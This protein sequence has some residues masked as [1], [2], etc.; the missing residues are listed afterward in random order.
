MSNAPLALRVHNSSAKAFSSDSSFFKKNLALG[1]SYFLLQIT[2]NSYRELCKDYFQASSRF[3]SNSST[4][5]D[6][7]FPESS[8]TNLSIGDHI[9]SSIGLISSWIELDNDDPVINDFSFQVLFNEISYA[10]FLGINTFLL[11]PPKNINNIQIY[12]SNISKILHSFPNISLSISLPVSQD[13]H[14]IDIIFYDSYSTWDMWNSIRSTC[15]YHKNLSVSLASPISNI[16]SSILDRWLLEPIKFY[17]ISSSRFIPNAKNYPVLQKFNQL[18]IFKLLQYKLLDPPCFILNGIDHCKNNT[19]TTTNNENSTTTNN[20]NIGQIIEYDSNKKSTYLSYIQHLLKISQN[21]N[22]L[23]NLHAFTL[24]TLKLSNIPKSLL[25]SKYIL[26]SPL[27]PS[28]N[29]LDNYTYN[30]F[31]EDVFK[32]DQYEKA[33]IKALSD[34]K[35]NWSLTSK[36]HIFFL[37]PGRGPL[38]DRFFS[39]LK[40]VDLSPSDFLI[41]AIERNPNVMIYLNQKNSNDWNDNVNILNLNSKNFIHYKNKMD[42]PLI[43]MVISELIGSFGCNELM[44]ECIDTIST[45]ELCH[46]DCIFIPQS[47]NCYVSPV[48][49][50]KIWKIALETSTDNLYVPLIPEMETLTE[51]PELVW[52]F[53]SKVSNHLNSGLN[54]NKH[55]SRQCHISIEP[56]KKG[57]VHGLAGYFSSVLYS[58]VVVDNLPKPPEING[59]ISWLP[60]FIPFEKSLILYDGHEISLLLNRICS[61]NYVWYEWSVECF[62]YMYVPNVSNLSRSISPATP[63]PTDFKNSHNLNLSMSTLPM[64]RSSS[65]K[66]DTTNNIENVKSNN[67]NVNTKNNGNLLVAADMDRSLNHSTYEDAS[68]KQIKSSNEGYS[69]SNTECKVKMCTGTTRIHN[70]NGSTFKFALS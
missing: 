51:N 25:S 20:S 40:F 58:D 5:F 67:T 54:S 57:V 37:G 61:D 69:S 26:Q 24:N 17:L 10:S 55:N 49:C 52:S 70:L 53:K 18:I 22:Y 30:L 45:P 19:V 68:L 9:P 1:Y 21:S 60:A 16:P 13:L 23:S 64:S 42:L 7:P 66:D 33:I 27:Q 50:P 14:D 6:V 36:P 46:S 31:E 47:L 2:N 44:P 65:D 29:N 48:Y 28:V 4:S 41:T 62:I 15:N 63:P 11:S 12:S 35:R 43:N 8:H 34:L 3:G 38:I 59:S 32:Y 56:N 39:A